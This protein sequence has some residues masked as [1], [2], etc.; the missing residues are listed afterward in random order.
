[1]KKRYFFLLLAAL[2]VQVASLRAQDDSQLTDL[3]TLHINTYG[4]A[5]VNSKET[6]V[7][8]TMHY[9]DG[10]SVAV[11]DSLRIRGRGNSTWRLPKKPYRIKFNQKEKFLGKG[12]AKAKS[13][14]LLANCSDK[15]MV[16]NALTRDLGEFCGLAFNPAARFVDLYLNKVYQG[17]YQISDQVQVK[18]HRV[19]IAEQDEV[20]T[21][22]SNISGGYLLEVDG[23]E[24]RTEKYFYTGTKNI[25][26]R[27]H[28]PDEEYLTISQTNYIR[29]VVNR[30]EQSL[31]SDAFAD[32]AQGYRQW[33]DT[34]SLVN[35]YICTEM[36]AN[37]DGFWST[38]FYKERDDD[39]L[40]FGPLWDF[41]IAWNN[42]SRTGNITNSLMMDAGFGTNLCKVWVA[43]MWK[44]PWF[45]RAVNRRW[46]EL[47]RGGL[48]QFL[49]D[50]TDSL[51][52]VMEQ[53][54]QQNYKKWSINYRYYNELV[55][56]STYSEYIDD[57]RTFIRGHVAFLTKT[58]A[59][60]ADVYDQP[61][62]TPPFKPNTDYYY[63]IFNKG[64]A[65]A[66]IDVA[67]NYEQS[68]EP[69]CLWMST[70]GR[71]SQLW[72]LNKIGTYF[73]LVNKQ[74]GLALADPSTP[75][76]L[77]T[78]VNLQLVKPSETNTRQQWAVVAQGTDGFYNLK[79]RY[80][81]KI[82]NN[83]G[84]A[85]N[86]GNAIIS[87]PSNERDATSDARLWIPEPTDTEVVPAGVTAT[88][89]ADYALAYD[90]SRQILHFLFDPSTPLP[91]TASV[92]AADGTLCGTFA[93]GH[94]FSLAPFAPGVYIVSWQAGGKH[95]RK[96][97]AR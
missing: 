17:T 3:P 32:P 15:A 55:L 36:S 10:D 65:L 80:T 81:Q 96:K 38:Y 6:Y 20:T 66:T 82:V 47:V 87:Y 39:K 59:E 46:Q 41:D 61:T 86:N 95:Y 60:R 77:G 69:V 44:D 50:K 57:L 7:L 11:Y 8:A 71:D 1:M 58:F 16:R 21:A 13:W 89:T 9:V 23:F 75:E 34:T 79:N 68:Q 64:V 74:T 37:V 78:S 84:H 42:C 43:Q 92:Y 54:Q 62:P 2:L 67:D 18:A 97:F 19:D 12:Y 24:D 28:Y 26:V 27:I 93:A 51:A 72:Q 91:I 56:H 5:P 31:F 73:Q 29:A 53:S 22:D 40:Y 88:A 45:A 94:D 33:V 76:E 85:S 52:R 90:R 49:L 35:W 14:T 70:N 48:E 83:R 25:Y 63:R 30:F 4:N